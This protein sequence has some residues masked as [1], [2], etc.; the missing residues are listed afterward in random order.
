MKINSG[1]V[2]F[3]GFG[4]FASMWK[5][6]DA[7]YAL[8]EAVVGDR[9]SETFVEGVCTGSLVATRMVGPALPLNPVFA[10]RVVSL[11]LENADLSSELSRLE[12]DI[13]PENARR[14]IL[15]HLDTH[16]ATIAL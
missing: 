14:V 9:S 8:G 3:V 2:D 5:L 16:F 15:K 1:G 4:D 10:D 12:T 13:Y 6:D 7:S 11:V